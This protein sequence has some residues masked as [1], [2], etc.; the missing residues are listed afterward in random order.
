MSQLEEIINKLVNTKTQKLK[1]N[2]SSGKDT[3]ST[4]E[5]RS[6]IK[7]LTTVDFDGPFQ[8]WRHLLRLDC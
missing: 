1:K 5:K 2:N 4:A 7:R 8:H 6:D 3:T